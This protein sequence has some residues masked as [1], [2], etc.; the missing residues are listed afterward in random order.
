MS[1]IVRLLD[2]LGRSDVDWTQLLSNSI[3]IAEIG[4]EAAEGKEAVTLSEPVDSQQTVA[5][6][7]TSAVNILP[8]STG[9]SSSDIYYVWN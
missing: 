8:V 5:N 7:V 4:V 9:S 1:D 2:A 3:N 6:E